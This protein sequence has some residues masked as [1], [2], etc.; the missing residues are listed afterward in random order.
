MPKKKAT[1]Y[2]VIVSAVVESSLSTEELE[3]SIVLRLDEDYLKDEGI[4]GDISV[5]EYYDREV[6]I[7][8]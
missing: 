2:V 3:D 7:E 5:D 8:E 4:K 6:S 1:R